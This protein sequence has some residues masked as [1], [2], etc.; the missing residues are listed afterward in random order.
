VELRVPSREQLWSTALGLY[1]SDSLDVLDLGVLPFEEGA[2]ARRRHAPDCLTPPGLGTYHIALNP[3]LPPLDDPR[4]RRA[5]VLGTDREWLTNVVWGG[6]WSTPTGGFVPSGMPGHS[7]EIALPYDPDQARGLLA[8]AGY[9]G[10]Q[11]FP[12]L[13]ALGMRG[14]DVEA[15][16]GHWRSNLGIEVEW[17]SVDFETYLDLRGQYLHHMVLAMWLADYPDPD[18][19]LRV[20]LQPF[21][22]L[23]GNRVYEGLVERARRL[24]DQSERMKLYRQADRMLVQEPLVMP[25]SYFR[26]HLLVKPWLSRF[27]TSPV[28]EHFWNDVVI[29]PH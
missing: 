8:A 20:A 14:F 13:Q 28:T 16:P 4:V 3:Q 5:F 27:P 15:L 2:R 18:N 26:G 23:W 17:Q 19:F 25:L 1:E 9:A 29:Q 7:A 22:G 12:A 21:T 11:G 6:L 10:G 24:T